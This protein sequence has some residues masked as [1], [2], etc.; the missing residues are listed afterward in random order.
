MPW[1]L[2]CFWSNK[3]SDL[4]QRKIHHEDDNDNES[5]HSLSQLSVHK[6][7]ACPEGHSAWALAPL[8]S[9]EI[10]ASGNKTGFEERESEPEAVVDSSESLIAATIGRPRNPLGNSHQRRWKTLAVCWP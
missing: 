5:D 4:S 3:E 9:G 7:L 2:R 8:L 1:K 6:T 10:L